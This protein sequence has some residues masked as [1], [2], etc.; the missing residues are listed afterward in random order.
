MLERLIV[1][2]GLMVS[3]VSATMGR[4]VFKAP[5]PIAVRVMVYEDL[6][7]E[8]SAR[9][10]EPLDKILATYGTRVELIYRDF[11]LLRHT[12]AA[13]AA[14]AARFF[15]DKDSRI[16]SEYRRQTLRSLSAVSDTNFKDR[17]RD[18]ANDHGLSGD[19]AIAALEDQRYVEMVQR[20]AHE[21][22]IRGVRQTPTVFVNGVRLTQGVT[23]KELT[24]WI[25]KALALDELD[26]K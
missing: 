22:V 20:D 3:T 19:D 14:V 5:A 12:W 21:G 11:P 9:L 13:R 10:H 1:V 8:D 24:K 25:D 16:A 26:R 15:A 7:C 18:F 2:G 23:L 6:Q 17:L 4:E